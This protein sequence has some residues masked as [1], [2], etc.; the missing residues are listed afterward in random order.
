MNPKVAL[1]DGTSI[2][3]IG[4]GVWQ[5]KPDET[6]A[7]VTHALEAGYRHVDTAQMY[8]NEAGVGA[9]LAASDLDR[10]D[11]FVTSK[12]NNNN[13]APADARDSI[14][15]TL[16][17]LQ[18]DYVDLFLIHWPLATLE[19]GFLDAWKVL[20]E[21]QAAGRIRSIGVSNFHPE[22]LD[23]LINETG[24]APVVNQVEVHPYFANQRGRSGE[25][26]GI[27]TQAWSP[28]ASGALLADEQLAAIAAQA[29]ASVAQVVL[30]WHLQAGR[31][32]L[33]KSVTPSRI[34]ENFASSQVSLTP[35]Q[36]AAIDALDRGIAGRTGPDPD[37]MTWV[38][39]R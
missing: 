29:E 26:R 9:A 24:V 39:K 28:L 32:I 19:V 7:A 11:V 33:P 15:R 37:E 35:D 22:H 34:V 2:P 4:F 25:S 27:V 6:Q 30:A 10:A 1:H 5:V 12:L 3:A 16:D 13:H 23:V 36:V 20:I 31:I 18:S 14:A 8:G 38:P 21:E 17:A